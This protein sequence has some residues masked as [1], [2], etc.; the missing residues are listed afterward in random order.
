MAF[1]VRCLTD[2]QIIVASVSNPLDP[3]ADSPGMIRGVAKLK[4]QSP[5]LPVFRILDL[6]ELTISFGEMVLALALETRGD[7]G[8]FSDPQVIHVVVTRDTLVREALEMLDYPGITIMETMG[9]ALNFI[10]QEHCLS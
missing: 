1:Q 3:L 4:E 7:P 2:R 8:S 5:E 10:Y 6:S 9:Q